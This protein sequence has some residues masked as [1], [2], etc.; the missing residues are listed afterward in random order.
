MPPIAE[1]QLFS[2]T[3]TYSRPN[4]VIRDLIDCDQGYLKAHELK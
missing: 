3:D 2:S 1:C 4:P